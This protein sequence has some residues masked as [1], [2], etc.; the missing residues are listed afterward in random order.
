MSR[1]AGRRRGRVRTR[2][3]Q[4][5][6]VYSRLVMLFSHSQKHESVWREW[7][8]RVVSERQALQLR[9]AGEADPVYDYE[10]LRP[11]PG[12]LDR[13]IE[14]G[15][16]RLIGYR[17]TALMRRGGSSPSSLDAD[18]MEA[19]LHEALRQAGFRGDES[20]KIFRGDVARLEKFRLWPFEGD[21]RAVRVRPRPSAIETGTLESLLAA[22]A[23]K[24]RMS[25]P[26][27]ARGAA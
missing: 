26:L 7:S 14:A 25:D 11:G 6:T 22:G 4:A 5:T 24:A 21:D 8:Y 13:C 20:D 19:L 9:A 23:L 17:A 1:S 10:G 27:P 18:T 2:A 16:V 3:E 12:A 15:S